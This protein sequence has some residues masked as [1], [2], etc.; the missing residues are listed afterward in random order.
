[1][2]PIDAQAFINRRGDSESNNPEELA[3]DEFNNSEYFYKTSSGA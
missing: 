1:M 3:T 2:K